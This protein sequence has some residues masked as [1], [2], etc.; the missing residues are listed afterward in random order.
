[1][2]TTT[3]EFSAAARRISE[4]WPAW[5]APIVGTRPTVRYSW[6]CLRRHW[7]RGETSRKT[8][9]VVFGIVGSAA[10]RYR[11]T[12]VANVRQKARAPPFTGLALA[13]ESEVQNVEAGFGGMVPFC[14]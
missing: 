6:S 7:R 14:F 1:M 4:R 3:A 5:S 9:M 8:M 2:L 12:V 13:P 10:L 11:I